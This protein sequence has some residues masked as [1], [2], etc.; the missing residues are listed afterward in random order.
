MKTISIA[1]SLALGVLLGVMIA[2]GG[3][4]RGN[5]GL[6]ERIEIANLWTQIRQW[7]SEIPDMDLDP[8]P[9]LIGQ[10]RDK[11]VREIERKVCPDNHNVPMTCS[12]ICS[13]ADNICDNA[14]RIC[15]LS[16]KLKNDSFAAG[17]CSSA[18]ASCS[19]AKKRCCDC[20]AKPP[21][22]KVGP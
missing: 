14:E 12:D 6:D 3:P 19:E 22:A 21:E 7:R 20:S 8:P 13:I 16:V 9:F 15:D 10:E 18:K 11:T 1:G 4:Q 5:P 17:K 2:C